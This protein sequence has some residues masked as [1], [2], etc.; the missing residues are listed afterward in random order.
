MVQL[1]RWV[2]ALVSSQVG[3]LE[4][5][6]LLQLQSVHL[7]PLLIKIVL[8]CLIDAYDPLLVHS[9]Q[10]L[11]QLL[12]FLNGHLEQL[13]SV[14]KQLSLDMC[15]QGRVTVE[16]WRMVD[17][18]QPRIAIAVDQDVKAEDLEA[19]VVVDVTGLRC[20]VVMHQVGLNRDERLHNHV[21]HFGLQLLNIDALAAHFHEDAIEAALVARG[22]IDVRISRVVAVIFVDRVV[23]QM[24][25]RIV[26]GLQLVLLG[27]EASK[28][29]AEQ[30]YPQ[31]MHVRNQNIHSEVELV[32]VDQ[33]WILDVLLDDQVLARIDLIESLGD[34]D[35]LPLRHRLRLHDK[36]G[37]RIGTRVIL[38]V[39]ELVREQ[40]GFGK[41]LVVTRKLLLHFVQVP[42]EVVLPR[43]LIHAWK[44]VDLLERFHF[45][46]F[47]KHGCDI[48]PLDIPL[49]VGV[50]GVLVADLPAKVLLGHFLD[51]IVDRIVNVEYDARRLGRLS[52]HDLRFL[53]LLFLF[54]WLR[55]RYLEQV[56]RLG[57]AII[58]VRILALVVFGWRLRA[59]GVGIT[60]A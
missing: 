8:V 33:V 53:L 37:G 6:R 30:E 21:S 55:S 40:P 46:P 17:L 2:Q 7:V 13:E 43:D 28:A 1:H 58:L 3:E 49:D 34:E 42:S 56:L 39:L 45:F 54:G 16:G 29:L 50:P 9:L 60:L 36:V 48:S 24:N 57:S 52:L 47:L 31:W 35:A 23:G 19:H 25:E 18:K 5:I 12:L 10:H 15:V 51:N 41:E 26:E 32:L 59:C 11:D 4:L 44:V 22:G 14:M 27:G 20:A 38:Q